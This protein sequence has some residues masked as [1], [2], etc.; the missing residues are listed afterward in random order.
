MFNEQLKLV[1]KEMLSYTL[2]ESLVF[3]NPTLDKVIFEIKEEGISTDK[4]VS[5]LVKGNRY[6]Y[7]DIILDSEIITQIEKAVFNFE[8]SLQLEKD[9]YV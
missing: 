6:Y 8:A 1:N 4:Y 2:P 3:F 7:F 9:N 5:I